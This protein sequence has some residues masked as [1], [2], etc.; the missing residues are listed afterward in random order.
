M[1]QR[2]A[3]IWVPSPW[4]LQRHNE[5]SEQGSGLEEAKQNCSHSPLKSGETTLFGQLKELLMSPSPRDILL[6]GSGNSA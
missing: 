2:R 1:L 3:E 5:G 6:K 4:K